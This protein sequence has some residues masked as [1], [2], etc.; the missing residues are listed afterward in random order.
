MPPPQSSRPRN[1]YE[2]C[3]L[4]K[5]LAG[6]DMSKLSLPLKQQILINVL[7]SYINA[8]DLNREV[9]KAGFDMALSNDIKKDIGQI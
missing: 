5:G 9:F 3:G 2:V 8:P 4:V 1:I 7:L 6:P